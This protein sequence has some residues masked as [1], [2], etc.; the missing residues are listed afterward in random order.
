MSLSPA[1]ASTPFTISAS[2]A[3]ATACTTRAPTAHASLAAANILLLAGPQTNGWRLDQIRV[4]GCSSSISAP[5]AAQIVGIWDDD[6]VTAWLIDEILIA[7]VTPSTL[8]ASFQIQ[9]V[10]NGLPIPAAHSL[11]MST[12]VTTTA[13]TTALLVT[14]SGALY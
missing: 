11:Y 10:Y 12:T 13:A 4:K 3:A 8:I 5:T 2:L 14:A 6:G 7:A 9:S 1:F